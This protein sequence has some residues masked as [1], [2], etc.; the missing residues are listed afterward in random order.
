MY[1]TSRSKLPVFLGFEEEPAT[2]H[3]VL[4]HMIQRKVE[5]AIYVY[6]SFGAAAL[7]TGSSQN[8]GGMWV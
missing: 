5:R 7:I 2:I 4:A 3:K 8:T 1:N 6:V